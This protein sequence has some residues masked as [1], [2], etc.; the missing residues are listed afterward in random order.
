MSTRRL[1]A[2]AALLMGLCPMHAVLA[3]GGQEVP[4][5]AAMRQKAQQGGLVSMI[6]QLRTVAGPVQAAAPAVAATQ[7][8][9]RAA[10][11]AM[12]I[13]TIRPVGRSPFAVVE[14]NARQLDE[15]I[16]SGLVTTV[17]ENVALVPHLQ[18]SVPLVR[19]PEAWASGANG[20]GKV[21]VVVDTGVDSTH[22]FLAGKVV[23]GACAAPDCDND[24]YTH[25]GISYGQPCAFGC[26]H[27][28]VV[29]GI[30]A[31]TASDRNGVAPQ[32]SIASIRV[33]QNSSS[34]TW[35]GLINALDYTRT[36]LATKYSI[37]AVNLSLGTP[38]YHAAGNCDDDWPSITYQIDALRAAG[39]LTIVSS[40]NDNTASGV[41][42]PACIKNA[43]AVGSTTDVPADNVSTFSNSGPNLD[44]LA[45]GDVITSS[46]PGGGFASYRG[47]SLAAPH[48]AGAVA[49]LR[50]TSVGASA[51]AAAIEAAIETSGKPV[52][53]PRNGLTKPRLDV[54]AAYVALGGSGTPVWRPWEAFAGVLASNPECLGLGTTRTD[55]WAKLASGGL[56][57]WSYNGRTAPSLVNL[58]NKIDAAP[59]C[60]LAGGKLQCFTS[61]TAGQLGQITQTGS[62]WSAWKSLGDSVQRRP[63]CVSL[64]GAK[65]TCV[66]LGKSGKLRTISWSGT[67]WGAWSGL[68]A[69]VTSTQAPICYG[70]AGGIDCVVVD[71][72]GKVQYLRRNSSGTWAAAKSLGGAVVGVGSCIEP[73]ATA[74]TCFYQGIDR[75]LQRLYFDGN[76]WQPWQNLGGAIFSAPNCV[77]F[78]STQ[79]HCF[80]VGETGTLQH[81]W[82]GAGN[83][84]QPWVSRGGALYLSRPSCIATSAARLDCFAWGAANP[85]AHLA[86]Y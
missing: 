29:A 77:W 14:V 1:A 11:T 19:A 24:P 5:A 70:R 78:G 32:A 45:P 58:G 85:L 39:I 13:R 63:A 40:G 2:L 66:A 47:T 48:V 21:V 54:A 76:A 3:V 30:V 53:D 57:W 51:S 74:R 67:K 62:T 17:E 60:L 35:E 84:W 81:I 75:T 86:Y 69:T 49:D 23:A 22:P 38:T 25:N 6:V 72:A 71:R 18:E 82:K 65:I 34:G 4:G 43:I 20:S 36:T 16:A 26:A 31:G 80:G 8:S 28:T 64:D 61:L 27:G 50:S 12:G 15:L 59:S 9:L 83:D 55:C 33:F 56:G 73:S 37:A 79:T 42:A 52:T 10:A 68:A 7:Q 44:M 41:S 46:V